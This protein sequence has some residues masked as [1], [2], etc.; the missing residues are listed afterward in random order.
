VYLARKH[1]HGKVHYVIRESFREQ[2]A[3]L[4][5]DLCDLGTDP[6][7]HIVYPGGNAFY[8]DDAVEESIRS[9]GSEPA[10][11]DMENMFWPFLRP[12]IRYKL[13]PFRRQERRLR[14]ERKTSENVSP[15]S[16]HF[17]DRRRAHFLKT[18]QMD[19]RSIGRLPAATWRGFRGK[20]RDE[21]E[22]DF[23]QMESVLRPREYKAYTY[24]IFNLQQFFHQ[25]FAKDTPELLDPEEVDAYFIEEVCRLQRDAA[26]WSGMDAGRSLSDYLVRYVIMYFDHDFASRSLAEEYIRDYINRHR[27]YRPPVS[28]AISMQEIVDILGKGREALKKMNRRDLWRLYRRRAQELHPDKGG[29]HDQ[30]VKLNEAYHKLLRTKR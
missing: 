11:D 13:E 4:W 20:S 2:E 1:I 9:L 23:M 15:E 6:A 28:I 25:R 7:R 27:Q 12:D 8:I 14:D 3:L 5:R 29:D 18:G 19:Q 26:F 30:F 17:F 21:I 16:I 24:V 22:Q 10:S